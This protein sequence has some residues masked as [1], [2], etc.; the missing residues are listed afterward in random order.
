MYEDTVYNKWYTWNKRFLVRAMM[1]GY[2]G[3]LVGLE[4]VLSDEDA[5]T[6]AGLTEMTSTQKKKIQ[7]LQTQHQGLRGPST[8]LH[9]RHYINW[10]RPRS[11]R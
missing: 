6:F 4:S 3:I 5:K 11:E 10:Y 8:V 7:Q 9:T 2:H 1:R